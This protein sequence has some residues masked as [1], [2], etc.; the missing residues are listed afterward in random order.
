[1]H[2][3]YSEYYLIDVNQPEL[4]SLLANRPTIRSY[5]CFSDF[6]GPKDGA[7]FAKHQLRSPTVL[8]STPFL[9]LMAKILLGTKLMKDF[10]L[11]SSIDGRSNWWEDQ[12]DGGRNWWEDKT[13]G[14]TKVMGE[15]NWWRI[16]HQSDP[17][18]I[19]FSSI[20]FVLRQLFLHHFFLHPSDFPPSNEENIKKSSIKWHPSQQTRK[21][22]SRTMS[23]KS[24][25]SI[26]RGPCAL[27]GTE[28]RNIGL[29]HDIVQ[30]YTDS[31]TV[32]HW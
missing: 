22:A 5:G 1:M 6:L 10:L 2:A 31:Q 11:F 29:L 26:Q 19:N 32:F 7:K 24:Y 20:S 28:L 17:P 13:D 25:A 16:L 27:T 4:R 30:S 23:V 21:R 15:Q 8:L 18:S 14:R 3:P 12:T 9:H